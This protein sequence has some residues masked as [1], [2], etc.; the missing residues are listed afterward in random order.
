MKK[1]E[2]SAKAELY[3]IIAIIIL[4]FILS[5]KSNA[6]SVSFGCGI[7]SS[8]SYIYNVE[9]K[10]SSYGMYVSKYSYTHNAE[11]FTPIP[12][13]DGNISDLGY[14]G[15]VFGVNKHFKSLSNTTLSLGMGILNKYE[16]YHT[17]KDKMVITD[18]P[19]IEFSAGKDLISTK[20][21][22][23]AIR[24]GINTATLI[25]GVITVGIKLQ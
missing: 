1:Y 16:F 24:G 8:N 4:L 2:S 22:T 13:I 5:I 23:I 7:S 20:Y 14:N 6:Q 11:V 19:V 17:I 3:S 10:T 15:I 12:T 25:F 18:I 21:T 9:F